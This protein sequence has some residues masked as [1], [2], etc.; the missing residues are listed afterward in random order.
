MSHTVLQAA[1]PADLILTG[2]SV[3]TVD[4]ARRCV[5]AVAVRGGLIVAVGFAHQLRD[6]I[7]SRT[8]VVDLAGR[9]LLPGFQDAHIHVA[10][11]GM[12]QM[13]CDLS[14][15]GESRDAYL[16][17]VAR[18]ASAH[19]DREW[20]LGSGWSVAAFP[21]GIADRRDLDTAVPHRPVFLVNKDGHGAWA[22]TSALE[23]CGVT[24]DT[25]DPD[26]GRIERDP[27]GTPSGTL[28]EGAMRLVRDRL[29]Q[30]TQAEWE[31]ALRIGQQHLHR[32]GITA[33]HEASVRPDLQA[34][35]MTL[36]ERGELTARA[37]LALL[38]ERPRGDEQLAQL[39]ERRRAVGTGRL[40]AH[41]V[42]FFQD[43]VIG[44]Y[45]AALLDPYVDAESRPTNER[46]P[47]LI[48]PNLLKR[49]VTLVDAA[50]FQVHVHAIGDRATR[51]ALD[52]FASARDANG[53]RDSRHQ[54]CHLQLVH[55]D[56]LSRFHA[57]GIIANLQPYWATND[58]YIP[59]LEGPVVGPARSASMY[60]FAALQKAGAALAFGSDWP[61]SSADPLDWIEVATTRMVPDEPAIPPYLP[62]QVLDLPNC[63]AA[64]TIG[65][66][67]ANFLDDETGT[68]EPGKRADLVVLDRDLFAPDAGPVTAA[69]VCLTLVDGQP[70]YADPAFDW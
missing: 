45:S 38:W 9:M 35:Y 58:S 4:A 11:G 10:S 33:W 6:L 1:Q 65:A 22:N 16:E 31:E 63:L 47:S 2:G 19:P 64:V 66:A 30:T 54:I 26:D 44:N 37:V 12:Q 17:A 49:Y 3:Y 13:Q 5:E 29:P 40:R 42:K 56:D 68:I 50:G 57:L 46:G 7:G 59:I 25:P 69:R 36:A 14:A 18:Y 20:I 55:P 48:E 70:V 28:Q 41:T 52:A 27:D 62:D 23:R 67:Y 60:R 15:A 24:S 61:V 8:R 34:A 21:G 32:L 51:E 43:G 53:R 39:V